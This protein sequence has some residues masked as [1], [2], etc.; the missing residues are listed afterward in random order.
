MPD[1][2]NYKTILASATYAEFK[3]RLA[4]SGCPRCGLCRSR[5]NIVVDRGDPRARLMVIGE[6]PGATEDREGRVFVGRAGRL[7]DQI[8]A[9]AG[10]DTDRDMVFGNVVRCRPP[11]NRPPTREEAEACYPYLQ[12]QIE[13]VNPEVILLLGATALRRLDP[14]K[15]SLVMSEEAGKFFDLPAFPQ[16]RFMVLY[17]PAAL[18]YNSRLRAHMERH[19]RVLRDF[20]DACPPR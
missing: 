7:F 6:A 20:L 17:H 16:I 11:Q 12:K 10:L 8:M 3:E 5:T 19:A 2:K 9:G 1:P 18:F 13:L 14:S 15:K 4:A